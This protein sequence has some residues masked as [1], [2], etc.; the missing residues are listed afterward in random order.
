[1]WPLDVRKAL[2]EWYGPM[3]V[4]SAHIA[5]LHR[6]V[7][8]DATIELARPLHVA[9]DG[10]RLSVLP[11]L[12]RAEEV[13]AAREVGILGAL[14]RVVG[15]RMVPCGDPAPG[16]DR[17]PYLDKHQQADVVAKLGLVKSLPHVTGVEWFS[18]PLEAVA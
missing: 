17:L 5:C 4:D 1:M 13:H 16:R 14:E 12:T 9:Y 2:A 18:G 8:P 11:F 7:D 10:R 6:C 3:D 15:A